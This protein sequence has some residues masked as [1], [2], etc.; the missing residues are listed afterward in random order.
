LIKRIT[1]IKKHKPEWTKVGSQAIQNIV[2]RLDESYQK[3]F[4][5]CKTKS[6]NKAGVP[7]FKSS[8]KYSSITF[9]QAGWGVDGNKLRIGKYNYKFVK[10]RDIEGKIKTCTIKRD[11]I[12]RLWVIFSCEKDCVITKSR[13]SKTA[14]FDFGLKQF[15]TCS[16]KT[17][18]DNPEFFRKG[19][20]KIAK[21]N[22]ELST[23]KR[24]GNNRKKA[25]RNLSLEHMR[26]ANKRRDWFF[27]LSHSLCDKFGTMFFE[28]LNISEMQKLWG[29]KVS[30]LSFTE[31]LNILKWVAFKRGVEIE[32]ISKWEP[33]TKRCSNCGNI[34]SLSLKN[35]VFDCDNCGLSI[36]RDY[37]A[38][39]NI[40]R[41]G[42]QA[43]VKKNKSQSNCAFSV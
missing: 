17:K 12:G 19:S 20:A 6:G 7:N 14:G 15:L 4:S 21:L 5:W 42:H 10:S 35:R 26:I 39:I 24:G 36:D 18:I 2:I 43:W 23:K 9:S 25:K 37:N 40:N 16:D 27:K 29:R 31:F 34:Q 8:I 30:D 33:T 32:Q 28:T 3:F 1:K 38:A 41:L 22:R 11:S 13:S